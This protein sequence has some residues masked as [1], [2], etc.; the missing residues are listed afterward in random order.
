MGIVYNRK[1]G[2]AYK[3]TPTWTTPVSHPRT[4]KVLTPQNI[5]YL[6]S[7]GLRVKKRVCGS[8]IG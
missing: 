7:L 5:R 1:V 4:A 3:L 2:S 6:K 8:G